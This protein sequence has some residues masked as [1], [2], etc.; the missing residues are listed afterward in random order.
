MAE[1]TIRLTRP[2]KVR[3]EETTVLTIHR[4][5][6]LGDLR[7]ASKGA[8]EMDALAIVVSRLCGITREEADEID[9][10]DV[11]AVSEGI[12]PFAGGGPGT[13]VKSPSTSHTPSTG[14]LPRSTP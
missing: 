12:A 3:G 11:E 9:A 5:A 10:A 14:P 4:R 7:A 2:I 8:D 1:G 13:G 6:N